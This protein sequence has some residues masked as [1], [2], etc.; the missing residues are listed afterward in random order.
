MRSQ[1][2]LLLIIVGLLAAGRTQAQTWAS[3]LGLSNTPVHEY[4]A[5]TCWFGNT[6]HGMDGFDSPGPDVVYRAN[7]LVV[8]RIPTYYGDTILTL[9]P[10]LQPIDFEVLVCEIDAGNFALNCPIEGDNIYNS[11]Q[12]IQVYI[13][14][15]YKTYRIIVT[16]GN[17]GLGGY[18]CGPYTLHVQRLPQ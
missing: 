16:S 3:P 10:R 18:N 12:P 11:Q 2:L 8:G 15:Q 7:N 14:A 5:D 9:Y 13:P 6:I 1:L 4:D 17:L